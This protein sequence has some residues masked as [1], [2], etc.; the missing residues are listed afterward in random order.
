MR[1]DD[2]EAGE[3]VGGY[4]V[5]GEEVVAAADG[6]E[7]AVRGQDYNGRDCGFEGAVEVGEAFEVEHVDLVARV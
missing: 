7:A 1:G 3:Q 4:A 5:G 2:E 6:G